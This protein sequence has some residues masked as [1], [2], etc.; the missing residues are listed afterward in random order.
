[1][2]FP[3]QA[4]L[5]GLKRQASLQVLLNTMRRLA[6]SEKWEISEANDFGVRRSV[7]KKRQP[8][9]VRELTLLFPLP[10]SSHLGR[11]I[12][13]PATSVPEKI[14]RPN[15]DPTVGFDSTRSAFGGYDAL[16]LG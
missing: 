6:L 4:P 1:M 14:G 12:A 9:D 15:N 13:A 7:Q 11:G 10:T 3:W 2:S 5:P 8:K 16:D